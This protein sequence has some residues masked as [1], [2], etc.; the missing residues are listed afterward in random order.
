MEPVPQSPLFGYRVPLQSSSIPLPPF[1][2]VEDPAIR[3]LVSITHDN[4]PVPGPVL[5]SLFRNPATKAVYSLSHEE[6]RAFQ[7]QDP[8]AVCREFLNRGAITAET[9]RLILDLCQQARGRYERFA[10]TTSF[11]AA[12]FGYDAENEL[13]LI[14]HVRAYIHL[15]EL[16]SILVPLELISAKTGSGRD[17]PSD[18]V[19][20]GRRSFFTFLVLLWLGLPRKNGHRN[21]VIH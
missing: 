14:L 4:F 7:T 16:F 11:R 8:S 20:F 18:L 21:C 5:A 1:Q 9:G 19:G 15:S 10:R 13:Q 2:L 3:A 17:D 6:L 12:M